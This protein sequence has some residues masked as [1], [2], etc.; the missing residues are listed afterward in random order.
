VI[1]RPIEAIDVAPQHLG[2]QVGRRAHL[3][4]EDAIAQR[5][6]R[7]DVLPTPR[8]SDLELGR[9]IHGHLAVPDRGTFWRS[10][11][12]RSAT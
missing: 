10:D 2:F 11:G 7:R 12:S 3:L 4:V 8:Q 6:R 5:L 9:R 1:A